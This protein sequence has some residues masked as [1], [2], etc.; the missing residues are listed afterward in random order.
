MKTIQPKALYSDWLYIPKGI[1]HEGILKAALTFTIGRRGKIVKTIEA[2]RDTG[3]YI[4]VPRE[5]YTSEKLLEAAGITIEDRTPTSYDQVILPD[6]ISF[7]DDVQEEAYKAME[8]SRNGILNLSCGYGKTVLAL[9]EIANANVPAVVVVHTS[10]LFEQWKR[11]IR[12][13]LGVDPGVMQGSMG[14][15]SWRSPIAIAM[16]HTLAENADEIPDEIRNYF[17]IACFDECL[18]LGTAIETSSGSVYLGD[19]KVGDRIISPKGKDITVTKTWRTIKEAVRVRTR[20]GG[21]VIAS[22]DHIMGATEGTGKTRKIVTLPLRECK[23]LMHVNAK[24]TISTSKQY[25]S[26]SIVAMESMGKI[27]L[28]DISVDSDDELFIANDF[29][30]HNC[31]HISAEWFSKAAPYSMGDVEV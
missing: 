29:I 17:G 25:S 30:V 14:K 19:I 3:D 4:A 28:M 11:E 23:H 18:G 8:N 1:L 2:Y 20:S 9:K 7:R 27:E 5:F 6:N 12:R 24:N 15:W 31:H 13:F 22:L 21:S 16:L 26:D 10:V